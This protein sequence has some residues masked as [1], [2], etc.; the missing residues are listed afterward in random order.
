M[1]QQIEGNINRHRKQ[2]TPAGRKFIK[3]IKKIS[4]AIRSQKSSNEQRLGLDRTRLADTSKLTEEE[5]S[6]EQTVRENL[7]G[8]L[9]EDTKRR[10]GEDAEHLR[11]EAEEQKRVQTDKIADEEDSQS[12]TIKLEEDIDDGSVL[13]DKKVLKSLI[14]GASSALDKDVRADVIKGSKDFRKGARLN[15]KE[16]KK[17]VVLEHQLE[18]LDSGDVD[19]KEGVKALASKKASNV[20]SGVGKKNLMDLSPKQID[21]IQKKEEAE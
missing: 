2:R 1:Y 20:I 8:A 4:S 7:G 10:M 14:G 17:V 13:Q 9:D 16:M 21:K 12:R 18:K 15:Q 19:K 3:A 11:E 6:K 5:E